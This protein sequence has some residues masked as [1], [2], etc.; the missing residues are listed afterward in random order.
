MYL[1]G[2]RGSFAIKFVISRTDLSFQSKSL[3]FP[4][5]LKA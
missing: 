2:P 5:K 4:K 3:K 1:W